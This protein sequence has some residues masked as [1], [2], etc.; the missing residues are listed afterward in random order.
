MVT[1][2]D[3]KAGDVVLAW[4]N[5]DSRHSALVYFMVEK[6]NRVTVQVRAENGHTQRAYPCV[7][8]RKLAAHEWRPESFGQRIAEVTPTALVDVALHYGK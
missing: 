8:T 3:L 7:F 2:G 1:T 6:V 5:E 4:H